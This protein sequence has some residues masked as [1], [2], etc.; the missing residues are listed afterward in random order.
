MVSLSVFARAE[1]LPVS[2]FT[3]DAFDLAMARKAMSLLRIPEECGWE[4]CSAWSF[5][6]SIVVSGTA[7]R[8]KGNLFRKEFEVLSQDDTSCLVRGSIC[9]F[10]RAVDA[11]TGLFMDAA[12][13]SAPLDVVLQNCDI[14]VVGA[15]TNMLYL[16]RRGE[17]RTKKGVLA[18]RNLMID[19]MGPS[20]GID[21]AVAV[22]NA[23]LPEG[24]RVSVTPQVTTRWT[25]SP[26]YANQLGPNNLNL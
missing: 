24:E 8:V 5:P 10:T 11:W 14:T 26:G 17:E 1:S 4:N 9:R 16:T 15:Q 23:G 7:Y 20:N 13:A 21:F 2:E 6:T 19:I 3:G 18:C 22:M 25:P 12:T